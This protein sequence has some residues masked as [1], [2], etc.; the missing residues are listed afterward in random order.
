MQNVLLQITPY[1]DFPMFHGRSVS[2]FLHE[3]LGLITT[4]TRQPQMIQ[5]LTWCLLLKRPL[6]P[7]NTL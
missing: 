2:G 6:T 1:A 5:Q 3:Y 4:T 7:Y